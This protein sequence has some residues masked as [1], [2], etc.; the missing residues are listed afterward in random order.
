MSVCLSFPPD[1]C[2]GVFLEFDLDISLNFFIVLEN[3][4]KLRMTARFSE[5][6]FFASKIGEMGKK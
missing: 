2:Q 3:L 5:K 4:M 6:T 1:I